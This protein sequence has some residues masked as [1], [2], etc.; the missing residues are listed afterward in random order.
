VERA[1]YVGEPT[2]AVRKPFEVMVEANEAAISATRPG[3]LL[4]DVDR[5]AKEVLARHGYATRTG[6]GCGRGITSYEG[7]ARELKM[8][9]R[10]YADVVLE[11]GMAFSLEPDL[12]VPGIGVYRHCNTIIVTE[13]GCEV[14]SR[15][16]RG[17]IWV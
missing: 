9:L 8:D 17:V 4:A 15:L 5:A 3:A 11:P 10:L 14:D 16:P 2:E 7:N 12:Q 1:V 13:D 6:S